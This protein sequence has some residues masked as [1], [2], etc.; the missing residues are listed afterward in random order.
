[1]LVLELRTN[2]ALVQSKM[3]IRGR[4]T[5][6]GF[7]HLEML[8]MFFLNSEMVSAITKGTQLCYM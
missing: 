7:L 3:T 1:M 4:I 5:E 8:R 6:A 2:R